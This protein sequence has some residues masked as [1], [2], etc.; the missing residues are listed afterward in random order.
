MHSHSGCHNND[1][2]DDDDCD[3]GVG[4]G[5]NDNDANSNFY[6]YR[7]G[8]KDHK[9][10]VAIQAPEEL[11]YKCYCYVLIIIGDF[12]V[13]KTLTFKMWPSA[14]PLWLKWV[15][16]AWEWKIISISK[17]EHLTSFWNRGP[18][19]TRKWPVALAR[20]FLNL[21]HQNKKYPLKL[22][23]PF[24]CRHKKD[25]LLFNSV[26]NMTSIN[27]AVLYRTVRLRSSIRRAIFKK[28]REQP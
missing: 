12:R 3:G 20:W 1:D 14:Q 25:I 19:E 10:R 9:D 5:N 26:C 23:L 16:F 24:S 11:R 7:R 22:L 13:S 27:P 4:D 2:D 8:S 18:G 21:F 6:D 28:N 17:A 15:L